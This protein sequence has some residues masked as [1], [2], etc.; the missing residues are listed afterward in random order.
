[1]T[2]EIED[3]ELD[4]ESCESFESSFSWGPFVEYCGE[5]KWCTKSI[6]NFGQSIVRGCASRNDSSGQL[7]RVGC[8]TMKPGLVVPSKSELDMRD[9]LCLCN[10]NFCN[11]SKFLKTTQLYLFAAII[12]ILNKNMFVLK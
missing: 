3:A 7:H 2:P 5:F 9:E 11:S 4:M 10:T 8:G 1:M 6:T 12:T